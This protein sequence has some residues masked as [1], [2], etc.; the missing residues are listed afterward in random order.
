[1]LEGAWGLSTEEVLTQLNVSAETG[2]SHNDVSSRLEKFG[3]NL[4]ETR[5]KKSQWTILFAQFRNPLIYFLVLAGVIAFFLGDKIDS[6]AILGIVFLNSLIGYFQESK[7]ESSIE[8][9]ASLSTPRARVLRQKKILSISSQQV[10]PGDI[11]VLEAGDYVVADARLIKAHQLAAGEGVLTGESLP[12]IKQTEK[13]NLDCALGD[14]S[15]MVFAGTAIERGSALAVVVATGPFSEVGK[16]AHMMESTTPSATPLQK[17]INKISHKFLLA[18]VVVIVL[19]IVIGRLQNLSWEE[20]IM[21]ALS[22]SVAAIPE[23]LPTVI[24]V[25][26]VMAINRMSK[27]HALIRRMDSVETLGSA[28]VICTDKTG[29]L[30]TGRMNVREIFP[31]DN[32]EKIMLEGMVLCNNA[33]L[34]GGGSGDSMEIALLEFAQSNGLNLS[35]LRKS[36]KRIFEWSFDSTR[37][38]M[39]MASQSPDFVTIHTKGAP[40]SVLPLCNLSAAQE[41]ALYKQTTELSKK[42]M[43]VLAF[44]YKKQ[45][46]KDFSH[47]SLDHI[48]GNLTFCGLVAMADPPRAETKNAIKIC[49]EAGIRIIMITGDHPETAISIGAELGINSL[50][51]KSLTGVD[52]DRLSIPE[53]AEMT[54]HISVYA[55]VSPANK[56]QLIEAL[57]MNSHIVAMTGDGV[58]DAPALKRA[59]IGVAMGRGGVEVA[60][61]A[62]SMVLT[63]DNFATIVDAV[64]EGRAVNENIKRTL[65]YLLS[66]NLAELMFI[67]LSITMGLPTPLQPIHLLWINLVTDGL[68][69]MA[70]AIRPAPSDFLRFSKKSSEETFFDKNFYF[71]MFLV[72]ILLTLMSFAIYIYGLVNFDLLTARSL[73]FC[74]LIYAILFRSLSCQSDIQ[75]LIEIKPNFLLIFS[76]ILPIFFQFQI[77]HSEL[78]ISLFKIKSL[79]NTTNLILLGI[80]SLPVIVV[81]IYKIWRRKR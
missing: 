72:G 40:E 22:L 65:Q 29:T 60:R 13:L 11:L 74:F 10:C 78:L 15:N 20:I 43:R 58:N 80:A 5:K 12:V 18:A 47:E 45:S 7:T 50:H 1:M 42:A 23:G 67:F 28:D 51:D 70:L 59:D 38:R 9:L 61:Q 24:S 37:K 6:Y 75:S 21:T 3:L 41:L 26:L 27:K 69:S 53:L 17:R 36:Q 16:I 81:E 2:L 19:V 46:S 56:L 25:A 71:E 14:R 55:R 49:Q 48:E 68:P 32:N 35:D 33:S 57:K 44:A 34:D 39:S 52:I 4:L 66:T 77:Q 73:T 63:D 54:K 64:A 79:S 30:T 31:F 62:S 8:A 76:V